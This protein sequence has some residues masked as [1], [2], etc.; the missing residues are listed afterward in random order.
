MCSL[1]SL[2]IG[3][4]HPPNVPF[5]LHG[6]VSPVHRL[7]LDGIAVI[8]AI[9]GK[10]DPAAAAQGLRAQVDSFKRARTQF[11][12]TG[13]AFPL[14]GA[15]RTAELLVASVVDLMR[16]V[17]DNTPLIHQVSR[18]LCTRARR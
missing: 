13:A 11:K 16:V 12:N 6:A 10:A 3:G 18:L 2:T 8:S 5:L 4:I 15:P 14:A 17:K 9:V 7:H 1:R